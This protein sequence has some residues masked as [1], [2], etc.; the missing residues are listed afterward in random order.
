MSMKI[1]VIALCILLCVFSWFCFYLITSIKDSSNIAE[2]FSILV[3][4]ETNSFSKCNA[5]VPQM[6]DIKVIPA[7]AYDNAYKSCFSNGVIRLSN[8]K[9]FKHKVIGSHELVRDY[10]TVEIAENDELVIPKSHFIEFDFM[11]DTYAFNYWCNFKNNRKHC[12]YACMK[13]DRDFEGSISQDI[14]VTVDCG[15]ASDCTR[16][17]RSM[18]HIKFNVKRVK[19]RKEN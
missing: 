9:E 14:H 6:T 13:N 19:A 2:T 18:C 11:G 15:S 4:N 17:D 12:E 7:S 10:G 1:D 16:K 3:E 8:F 5:L